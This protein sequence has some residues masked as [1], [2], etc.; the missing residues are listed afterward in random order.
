MLRGDCK[1]MLGRTSRAAHPPKMLLSY[2][3][4]MIFWMRAM[5]AMRAA[6]QEA[7]RAL[8]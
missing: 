7:P 4:P 8:S 5:R 1:C 3:I 6:A 2:V